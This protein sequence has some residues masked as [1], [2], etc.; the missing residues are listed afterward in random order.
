M[1]KLASVEKILQILYLYGCNTHSS[2]PANNPLI[3]WL[4]SWTDIDCAHQKVGND[5]EELKNVKENRKSHSNQFHIITFQ[6]KKLWLIDRNPHPGHLTS[7][8]SVA[9]HNNHKN[10]SHKI[11]TFLNYFGVFGDNW[12]PSHSYS[13]E[14]RKSDGERDNDDAE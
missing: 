8:V 12:K 9:T 1:T 11:Y 2:L 4:S 13:N 6:M 10:L 14:Q 7:Q 3:S 5:R